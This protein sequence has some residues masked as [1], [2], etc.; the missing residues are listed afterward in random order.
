MKV[1]PSRLTAFRAL[2]S[3]RK[4][5]RIIIPPCAL[6]ADRRLSERIVYGVLQ[7]ELF[8]DFLLSRFVKTG[9]SRLHPAVLDLLRLSAFQ[10]LFLDRIPVSA[11]VN[12]AVSI[13]RQGDYSFQSGF[14]N[15]VLRKLA[16]NKEAA[17]KEK[18]PLYIHYSHPEWMVNRLVSRF[19]AS[20]TEELLFADQAI[21]NLRIQINTNICSLDEYIIKL[22]NCGIH[23]LSVNR[24]L[25]SVLIPTTPVETLPGYQEGLFFIQDDAARLSVHLAGIRPGMKLLDACAAPGGKSIA[26]VLEGG[27][28]TS[29][30]L[31]EAR[32]KRCEGNYLRLRM[33]IPIQ[34]M[35]ASSFFP[36]FEASFPLVIAD[37]PCSGTGVIRK[38]PEIRSKSEGDF[39]SLLPLQQ[40]ILNNLSRYVIPG[41]TLMYSTCSIMEEE[42]EE[43]IS[44]FLSSHSEFSLVPLPSADDPLQNGMFHSW[45]NISGNDGFFAAKLR[46][47]NG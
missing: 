26:S 27:N 33:E 17:L 20:F 1:S 23:V 47:N 24:T 32:L 29:C 36:S 9:Y 37:V 18:P 39:F 41:G 13:C 6:D 35:D 2:R 45:P 16:E 44:R 7:N 42:N 22:Q 46:K 40:S 8:L 14:V 28:P 31:S 25:S 12:D 30:D 34:V 43:Q 3:Y 15:A 10:I 11:V 21:P 38:H 19:G 5:A 4:S